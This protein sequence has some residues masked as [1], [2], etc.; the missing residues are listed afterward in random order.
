MPAP[1]FV[2]LADVLRAGAAAS[3]APFAPAVPVAG[4]DDGT[5]VRAAPNAEFA[6]APSA[7]LALAVEPHRVM[8]EAGHHE[9]TTAEAS[10]PDVIAAAREARLFRARLADAFDDALARLLRELAADVL[11]RELRLAPCDVK[12]IAR[13]VILGAPVVRVRVSP[14]ETVGDFGLPVVADPELHPGDAVFELTEGALD[15]RLGV[16]LATVLDA[17]AAR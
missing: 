14:T 3:R 13:R 4:E 17:E 9:V 16:R 7:S 8:T 10:H 1:E 11:A 12:D 2:S 6:T 15:A 5:G